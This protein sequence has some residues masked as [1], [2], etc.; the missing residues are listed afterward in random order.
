MAIFN[1]SFLTKTRVTVPLTS[2]AAA[3]SIFHTSHQNTLWIIYYI[4]YC[5]VS[6]E[7][8]FPPNSVYSLLYIAAH[9]YQRF[10]SKTWHELLCCL[11]KVL[12]HL[13]LVKHKTLK[14]KHK[15]S[16]KIL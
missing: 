9:V 5:S 3:G 7:P 2:V 1:V 12:Q 4:N 8:M 15:S 11:K 14:I 13:S 16:E 10:D 6:F